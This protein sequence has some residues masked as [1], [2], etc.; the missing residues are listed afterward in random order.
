MQA[1]TTCCQNARILHDGRGPTPKSRPLCVPVLRGA[2]CT[3]S[4][5]RDLRGGGRPSPDGI[6]RPSLSRRC[7]R[8]RWRRHRSRSRRVRHRGSASRLGRC[9]LVIRHRFAQWASRCRHSCI[10]CPVRHSGRRSG[11]GRLRLARPD[12]LHSLWQRLASPRLRRGWR[13]GGRS[14]RGVASRFRYPSAS[15]LGVGSH[16]FLQL[17]HPTCN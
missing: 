16:P 4:A 14:S 10:P 9:L 1:P 13:R 5:L 2:R 11:W 8:A 15:S 6:F 3:G 12:A 7:P 17:R